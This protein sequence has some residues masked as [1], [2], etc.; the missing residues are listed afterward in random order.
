MP[1]WPYGSWGGA[2]NWDSANWTVGGVTHQLPSEGSMFVDVAGAAVTLAAPTNANDL[3]IGWTVASSVTLNSNLTVSGSVLVG[4]SGTLTV[5]ATGTLTTPSIDLSGVGDFDSNLAVDTLNVNSGATLTLNGNDL[6]VNTALTLNE[7]LDMT[8]AGEDLNVSTAT[9]T[10][11]TGG[12]LTDDAALTVDTLTLSG[13]TVVVPG[14]ITAST[15]IN[16]IG[17]PTVTNVLDGTAAV[18]I[19]SPVVTYLTLTNTYSGKTTIWGTLWPFIGFLVADDG[20]GLP[21]DSPLEFNGGV[22][23]T[24]GTLALYPLTPAS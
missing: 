6:T 1:T 2:A 11:N 8:A 16:L 22:L 15:A 13:G 5:G 19:G 3:V 18:S 7:S 10:L 20:V 21:A 23:V 4:P 17:D 12:T 24:T 14:T 9:V